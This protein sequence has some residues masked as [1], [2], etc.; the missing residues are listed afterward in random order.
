MRGRTT[1]LIAHRKSTL[2]LAD[3]IAVLNASGTVEDI[4]THADSASGAR[5]TEC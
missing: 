3:R 2:N 4:G 5:S 1:L